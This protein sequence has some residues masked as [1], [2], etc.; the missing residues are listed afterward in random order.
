[1]WSKEIILCVWEKK[2]TCEICTDKHQEKPVDCK[3]ACHE[4]KPK[5]MTSRDLEMYLMFGGKA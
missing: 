1:M 4:K 3:C 5:L 2:M